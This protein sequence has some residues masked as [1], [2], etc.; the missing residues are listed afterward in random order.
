MLRRINDRKLVSCINYTIFQRYL[1]ETSSVTT[2]LGKL[3]IHIALSQH[4][5]TM[6]T[7]GVEVPDD[8]VSWWWWARLEISWCG[9]I[10][11]Y[12][13]PNKFIRRQTLY[14]KWPFSI[15]IYVLL[16]ESSKLA[17]HFLKQWSAALFTNCFMD[18]HVIRR[19]L[20]H[21]RLCSDFDTI[22]SAICTGAATSDTLQQ[23]SDELT[24]KR[25]NSSALFLFIPQLQ[26]N[27][28]HW[29]KKMS[30]ETAIFVC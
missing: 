1:Q 21:L 5:N 14:H 27:F 20:L 25:C 15:Y 7:P 13:L 16:L 12:C 22:S 23:D 30:S 4:P 28:F 18:P 19:A 8:N 10:T 17:I 3:I 9:A 6:Y 2:N 11:A 26:I 29:K 24:Q